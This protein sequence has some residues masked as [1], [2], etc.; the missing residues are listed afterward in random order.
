VA[1]IHRAGAAKDRV[2][3]ETDLD[4]VDARI[5]VD[6]PGAL[7]DREGIVANAAMRRD[8]GRN[9]VVQRIVAAAEID[10]IDTGRRN[11]YGVRAGRPTNRYN[12]HSSPPVPTCCACIVD[13]DRTPPCDAPGVSV[14]GLPPAKSWAAPPLTPGKLP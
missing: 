6:Q 3:A 8:G 7:G 2:G 12:G 1:R 5:A 13:R 9:I 10:R 4:R 14:D 11:R